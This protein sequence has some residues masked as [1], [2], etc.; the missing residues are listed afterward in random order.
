MNKILIILANP[1]YINDERS[2]FINDTCKIFIENCKINSLSCDFID[3]YKDI[4]NQ[5]FDPVWYPEKKDNKV[6]EYQVRIKNSD[7]IAIFYPVWWGFLPASLKGFIEKVFTNGFAFFQQKHH[8]KPL[9]TEKLIFVFNF[10]EK[11]KLEEKYINQDYI[12]K[13]W[14]RT[15]FKNCG[16][17]GEY[18][19]FNNLRIIDEKE[20]KK[21][22]KKILTISDK[23]SSKH[24][25]LDLI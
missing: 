16:F 5:E 22:Q 9:L 14:L 15:F 10:S 24:K 12:K 21:Y 25:I 2:N 23:I 13:F 6:L 19:S 1:N 20:I 18:H 11:S 17:I 7:Y 3:L 4:E 8:I